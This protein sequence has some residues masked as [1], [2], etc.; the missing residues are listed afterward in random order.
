MGARQHNTSDASLN[1]RKKN[2]KDFGSKNTANFQVLAFCPLCPQIKFKQKGKRTIPIVH[3][4]SKCLVRDV[5]TN[6]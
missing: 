5:R 3:R 6:F 2:F 1:I 4:T